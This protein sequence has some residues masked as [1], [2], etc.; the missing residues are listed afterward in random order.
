MYIIK[1]LVRKLLFSE[2]SPNVWAWLI[3]LDKVFYLMIFAS[4]PKGKSDQIGG[5]RG[6][7]LYV[8]VS[9]YKLIWALDGFAQ[10]LEC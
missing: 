3:Y 9:W 5:E 7:V 6:I 8:A 10:W 2:A 4:S 1:I